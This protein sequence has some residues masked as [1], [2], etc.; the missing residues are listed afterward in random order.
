MWSKMEIIAQTM[1]TSLAKTLRKCY[2]PE[3]HERS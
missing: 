2:Y 3:A 1:L